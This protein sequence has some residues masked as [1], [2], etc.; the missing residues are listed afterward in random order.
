[1]FRARRKDYEEDYDKRAH[2]AEIDQALVEYHARQKAKPKTIAETIAERLGNDGRTW[3]LPDGTTFDSLVTEA[4]C[5]IIRYN[6]HAVFKYRF[7]D[8]SVL[9]ETSSYWFVE[10]RETPQ[11]ALFD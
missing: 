6:S 5:E 10:S 2:K 8:G 9:V 4:R 3:E 11:M 1:M 7:E